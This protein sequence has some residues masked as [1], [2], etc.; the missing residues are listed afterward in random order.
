MG[1]NRSKKPFRLGLVGLCTSHPR[2]WVPLIR[3]FAAAGHAA[4]EVVAAWDSAETQPTGFAKTF[5]QEFDIPTATATLDEMVDLV[6]GVIVHTSNWDRHIDHARPFVE[7]DKTVLIDKPMF[8]RTADLL[9]LQDWIAAGRRITGGSSL[10]FADEIQAYLS[11]PKQQEDRPHT[12]FG[13][14]GTDEFF[15]GIHGY[16]MLCGLLGGGLQSVRCLCDA[17]PGPKTLLAKLDWVDGRTAVLSLAGPA[18]LPFHLTSVAA[19]SVTQ[20]TI[21]PGGVYRALLVRCLPYLCRETDEP[22][23]SFDELVEPELA[24]IAVARSLEH[25]GERVALSDLTSDDV[26]YDGRAFACEYRRA[27]MGE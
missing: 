19:G 22:P 23:L 13:G 16:A 2:K 6:D 12:V 27:R 8:G 26:Y 18:K 9:V 11:R 3:E 1:N 20:L 25:R 4:V 17:D 10:R 15:Y 24:A 14:C 21:D 7:S 5:C